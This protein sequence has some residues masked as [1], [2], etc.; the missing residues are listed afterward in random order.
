MNWTMTAVDRAVYRD[1]IA[2]WLPARILDF[3]V[4]VNL[5]EHTGPIAP[6]RI[7]S[8]W[9]M[10]VGTAQPWE[11]LRATYASLFPDREVACV[12]FG[13]VY[14]ETYTDAN[15]AYVLAGSAETANAA[16]A[17]MCTRPEWHA[18]KVAQGL[19][20]GFAG[21]K[22]YPDFV[23]EGDG[24]VRVFDFLPHEHLRALDDAAGIL[25]LHLP[26]AGRIGDP[27][28]V[29]EVLEIRQRYPRIKMVIAHVGRAYCLPTAQRGLPDLARNSGIS[30]DISANLNSDVFRYALET[31][32][33]DRLLFG[34]DLPITLLRGVRE[35]VGEKYINYVSAPYSWNTNRKSPEEEAR[36][37]FYLYE[38]I[39]ALIRAIRQAGLGKDAAARIMHGNGARLLGIRAGSD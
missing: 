36:Y 20:Q 33:P 3:H 4:H 31:V 19:A 32:G 39:R 34:S 9:A 22:P 24:E 27:D 23:P 26:R 30:F 8:N 6:E 16:Y 18:D 14:R 13:T 17:L 5:P 15:N 38:E 10:E 2:P 25:M 1:E 11:G 21:I 28:N 12:A 37:T 7:A 35:H 29:R